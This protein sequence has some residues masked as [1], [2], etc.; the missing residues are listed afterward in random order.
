[1]PCFTFA[2]VV[3]QEE[4]TNSLQR[5]I[6]ELLEKEEVFILFAASCSDISVNH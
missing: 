2:S 1:M 4:D 5:E 6:E 3:G